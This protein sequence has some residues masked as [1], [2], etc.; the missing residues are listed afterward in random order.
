MASLPARHGEILIVTGM[1]I[2][3]CRDTCMWISIIFRSSAATIDTACSWESASSAGLGAF[4][5]E[6]DFLFRNRGDGT[7]ED[8]SKKAG[9]D[10]SG[11]QFGMQGIW[12][13]YDN[14]GWPDLYVANDAGTNY[15]YRNKHDGTFEDVSMASGTAVS[16][17]GHEQGSMGVDFGDIDH[18]GKLDLIRHEFHPAAGRTVL[19]PRGAGV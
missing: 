19:E 4:P 16:G 11:L 9:V 1:W 15:L 6:T 2:C 18:D 5:G 7:F 3:S 8:V 17:D 13:D 12:A 10:D 14:D